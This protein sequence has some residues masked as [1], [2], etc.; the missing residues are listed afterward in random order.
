MVNA[1]YGKKVGSTQVFSSSGAAIQVTAIE[2]EPCFVVQVKNAEKDGYHAVKIGFGRIK[3]KNVNK[4]A[5]G[6]FKKSGTQ[7]KKYFREIR[8]DSPIEEIKT[9]DQIDTSIF[10]I[11]DKVKI[12]GISRGKGF[13][14]VIKRHN[15]HRGPMTHGSHNIRQPGSIGMCATPSKVY[16]GRKMPGR[17]GGGKVTVPASEILDIIQDLNLILVKG[18]V[19]GPSGNIVLVK[20]I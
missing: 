15:F 5:N 3:E 16:K 1:I 11:G 8:T 18:N 19:P 17:M 6:I 12:S 20:K 4:P 2:A 10:K 9:G 14:G 13:A 7:V